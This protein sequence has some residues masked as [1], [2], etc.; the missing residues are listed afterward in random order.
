MSREDAMIGTGSA[1]MRSLARAAGVPV[2]EVLAARA[3]GDLMPIVEKATSTKR[4]L[5]RARAQL[6]ALRR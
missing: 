5:E 3:A 2:D 1:A 6:E 4:R